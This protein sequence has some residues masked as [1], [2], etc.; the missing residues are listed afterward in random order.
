VLD[1][2]ILAFVMEHLPDEIRTLRDTLAKAEAERPGQ[3]WERHR[4]V[5]DHIKKLKD[6]CEETGHSLVISLTGKPGT[7]RRWM[8]NGRDERRACIMCG[9]EEIGKMATGFIYR[10]LFRKAAW[11]FEKLNGHI[12]RTF[13]DPEW[14][15]ETVSIFRQFSFPT[16]VVLYH[17][18]PPRIPPSVLANEP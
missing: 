11:R 9:T 17:A 18:F 15:L 12:T 3:V 6:R 2:D 8:R 1:G 7:R 14:Y 4:D 13:T 5:Y 16:D 10:F